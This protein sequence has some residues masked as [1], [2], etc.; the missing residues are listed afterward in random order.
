MTNNRSP[1]VFCTAI[2][3]LFKKVLC[4]GTSYPSQKDEDSGTDLGLARFYSRLEVS[5]EI[6]PRKLT[7]P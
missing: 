5:I 4:L 1:L 3:C 6:Y 2:D 7:G